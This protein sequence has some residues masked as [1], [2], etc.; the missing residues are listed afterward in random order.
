MD[1]GDSSIVRW[2]SD[3]R[4]VVTDDTDGGRPPVKDL[5]DADERDCCDCGRDLLSGASSKVS[6]SLSELSALD[7]LGSFSAIVTPAMAF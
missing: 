5:T 6:P 1:K 4:G 3:C 2:D 7:N